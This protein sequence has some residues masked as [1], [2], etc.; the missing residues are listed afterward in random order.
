MKPY[1]AYFQP[2]SVTKPLKQ[3]HNIRWYYDVAASLSASRILNPLGHHANVGKNVG[4][5]SYLDEMYCTA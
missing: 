2:N 4:E 5:P 1:F 3:S